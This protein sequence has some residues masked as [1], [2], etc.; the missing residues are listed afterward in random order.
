MQ[1]ALREDVKI[2]PPAAG[3]WRGG[4]AAAGLTHAPAAV[5]EEPKFASV[6]FARAGKFAE[7]KLKDKRL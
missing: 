5:E 2:C 1:P 7:V 4:L 6:E 3:G